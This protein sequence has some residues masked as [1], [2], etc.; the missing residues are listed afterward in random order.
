MT[1]HLSRQDFVQI[2]S[3]GERILFDEADQKIGTLRQMIHCEGSALEVGIG[4]NNC[5]KVSA[6]FV[7]CL[8]EQPVVF[9]RPRLAAKVIVTLCSGTSFRLVLIFQGF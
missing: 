2:G 5:L 4:I 8:Q 1:F 6:V 9:I 3:F 7:Q